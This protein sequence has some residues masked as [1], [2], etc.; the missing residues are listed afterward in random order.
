M[1]DS[2]FPSKGMKR[3][4]HENNDSPV[5]GCHCTHCAQ[6]RSKFI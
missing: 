6:R 3:Q 1:K 2:D 5:N 4:T